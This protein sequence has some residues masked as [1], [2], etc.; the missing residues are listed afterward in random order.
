MGNVMQIQ[1]SAG[2]SFVLADLGSDQTEVWVSVRLYFDPDTFANLNTDLTYLM[3]IGDVTLDPDTFTGVANILYFNSGTWSD[4]FNAG[5][6][7]PPVAG[8]WQNC[9]FHYD[10]AGPI[11]FYIGGVLV[12][13]DTGGS[14]NIRRV[15]FGLMNGF[16]FPEAE[17][18]GDVL[19]GTTRGGGDLFTWPSS[20][21]DLSTW[22][23]VVG[24]VSVIPAPIA[25][26]RVY[27]IT[28][29]LSDDG[30]EQAA[31]ALSL[32]GF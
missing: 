6:I 16:V 15:A 21:T 31:L 23:T 10:A 27:G 8:A 3:E 4:F 11:D 28:L 9:E 26:T 13:S 7:P 5:N 29:S 20:S 2:N 32:D 17:L 22:T 24:D 30:V 14:S 19:I 25:L 18:V 12:F 1:T